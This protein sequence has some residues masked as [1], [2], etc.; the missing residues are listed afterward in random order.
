MT[1]S[2][3]SIQDCL[4]ALVR[5]RGPDKTICPSEVARALADTNWR[6][7]MPQVR[8]VG[9]QLARAGKIAVTQKGKVV[10][11]EHAKGPIRYRLIQ[12]LEDQ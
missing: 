1:I 5:D 4:L 7:W 12:T 9:T 11:P 3:Q 2:P 8:D 10:D 6:Q